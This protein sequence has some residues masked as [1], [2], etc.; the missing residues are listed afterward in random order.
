MEFSRRIPAWR[1]HTPRGNKAEEL[2]L[3]TA[4]HEKGFHIDMGFVPGLY[5]SILPIQLRY[6][7][8][9]LRTLRG[10]KMLKEA[11]SDSSDIYKQVYLMFQDNCTHLKQYIL[12]CT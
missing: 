2:N 9:S 10:G 6:T 4:I 11:V 3:F 7:T 1:V 12:L 5:R 8:E